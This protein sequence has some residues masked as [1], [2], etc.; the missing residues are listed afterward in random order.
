MQLR[1]VAGVLTAVFMF[2]LSVA[3]NDAACAAH[4]VGGHALGPRM[5]AQ[6]MAA[7]TTDD[8][9]SVAGTASAADNPSGGS[10]HAKHPC[11]TP[12][13]ADCC[14]AFVTCS[15]VFLGNRRPIPAAQVARV[16]IL[17][18]AVDA[19]VSLIVAPDPPP[20]KA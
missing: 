11:K 3:A 2:H 15:A 9:R 14:Q 7:G 17:S 1:R 19:P 6:A 4:G 13:R 18:A 12:V 5:A 8:G 20:P 10:G 16:K